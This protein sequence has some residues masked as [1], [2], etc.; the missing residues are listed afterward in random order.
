M[1]T[2]TPLIRQASAHPGRS[3]SKTLSPAYW[4]Y[5]QFTVVFVLLIISACNATTQDA[6]ALFSLLN[7]QETHLSFINWVED[8]PDFN[9]LEYLYF[10]DGGGVAIGDV[11]NDGLL[12]I[13]LT[14]N[15]VPNKLYLNRGRFRF[16]DISDKAAVGGSDNEW[17]TGVTMADVNGDGW[18]DIYVCQVNYKSKKGHNLLYINNQDSTFTEQ[19]AAY[20]LDFEGLSTQAA[21]FDY[22]RDG[23]LDLYLLNHS[24]HTRES[25]VKSW[26][27]IVDA[28]RVGDRLY[29]NDGGR[30]TNVTAEAGIYSSV[31]GYGLGLAISDINHDGWPDIYIG[32]DFHE[33]DYL[34]FNNGDGT[35]SEALQRVIG[36]TSQSSMGNDIADFNN[37]G[38]VDIVSLDMLPAELATYRKSGGP[39][40]DDLARIKRN[41]G[42]AP[43]YARNTL[44]VNRGVD[45]EGFPLF[46]E[47]GLY[48]GIHATDWSWAA[49]FVDLD[50]DGW[51]DLY[52][53]N[54]IPRRPNDLDYIEYISQ[55]TIQQVLNE[56]SSEEQRE[57]TMRMPTL[58]IS[59]YAFRN[60]GNETFTDR[61]ED[62]GLGTQG[63]SNGAAY[64]DLD[65]DG[66]VDLVVN[67][68]NRPAF[69]YR[70]NSEAAGG[71]HYLTVSLKGEGQNTTGIGTKILIHAD[72][73][74]LYQEQ[75]PTRGFQSSVPH[76]L[77]FG[78]GELEMLDSLLVIWPDGR[79]QRLS[80]VGVDQ[81][82]IL[83]QSDAEGS[84]SYTKQEV[85]EG[86]FREVTSPFALDFRHREDD[87]VDYEAQPLIPHKLSTQGPALA[88]ADV[89]GDGLDDFYIGGAHHQAGK[90]FI[91][92][93]GG[94]A[95]SSSEDPFI[96]DRESEDVDAAFFD[97]DGDGDVDLYVVSGGGRYAVGDPVLQDRLY[98]NDGEGQFSRSSEHLPGF[99]ADGCCVAPAD[100]DNDGDIDLFVGSR[101]IPGSYGRTPA[102]YLLENDGT[103]VF[104][105]VTQEKA[106][107]L[108]DVGMVT[109]AIWTNVTGSGDLDLVIAGEWMPITVLQN[110]GGTLKSVTDDIGLAASSGWWNSLLADD[111]DGDGDVDLVAGNLG[112]NSVFQASENAPLELFVDDFDYNATSDPMV[113][114]YR[115]GRLFTWARR[116]E[117]LEQV[118]GLAKKLSTYTLYSG[119]TV[120]DLFDSEKLQRADRK[121]VYTFKS[122]YFENI[123]ADGFKK[124]DLPIEA[125]WSPVMSM[126]SGDFNEDGHKDI[127]T[128]GNFFGA[129]TKQG[130]YDADYGMLLIGD[131]KGSFELCPV[132]KS[133]FIVRGEAREVR[134]IRMRG[135]ERAVIVARNNDAPQIFQI[136]PHA[137][138]DAS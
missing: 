126:L 85:E 137:T 10:Y 49:L 72:G 101:S 95:I 33:N 56:G 12:D 84:Y 96:Q 7:E 9:I 81:P 48:A 128:V 71:G 86:L 65:N 130:R 64:G 42:Y 21:F 18:L 50:N 59:N 73:K 120:Q 3:A 46:S 74:L 138:C 77:Y 37:D 47:I 102:S 80:R 28:P 122:I 121:S 43:Q 92:L 76:T 57:V 55:P 24:V 123:G 93:R 107:T 11:N 100:Y 125:Q 98:L 45:R 70:N 132:D 53:T 105:D 54:G 38:R 87:F 117:L 1:E 75:M 66:D 124:H 127:L 22:D 78:L 13:F 89:N 94:G 112:T 109:D 23:D 103:G 15:Q 133:K 35:F 91:Q 99:Y 108:L 26:R 110:S 6:D 113:A 68:I 116:D 106:R 44:Q 17:S 83:R 51:K 88:V 52:V 97:A 60:N 62:W 16:E 115:N 69:I 79:F 58:N 111:F 67:N 36:H 29:R 31:L 14:G 129:D 90:L 63:Y 119:L 131:G 118:P 40:P 34:Y 30:F 41:F 5:A 27:R 25:F 4:I 82:L 104:T 39:D 134:F 136:E 32:N 8:E 2:E 61:A 19:A 135:D 114:E 20:G